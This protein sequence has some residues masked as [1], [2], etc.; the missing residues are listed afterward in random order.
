MTY[1]NGAS[2]HNVE[3]LL[4]SIRTTLAENEH[5]NITGTYRGVSTT[6]AGGAESAQGLV[7]PETSSPLDRPVDPEATAP[8]RTLRN[9]VDDVAEFELPAI[10]KPAPPAAADKPN[11]LLGRLSDALMPAPAG[12]PVPSR[13]VIRFEPA[14]SREAGQPAA[15]RHPVH[16]A[17]AAGRGHAGSD[18][19]PGASLDAPAGADPVTRIAAENEGVKREMPTFFDT[20]MKRLGAPPSPPPEPEPPAVA[21]PVI[22]HGTRPAPQPPALPAA[23]DPAGEA[24]LDDAAAQMLRPLLRQWLSENMPKI[25]EKALR[26]EAGAGQPPVIGG[27][28]RNSEP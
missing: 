27:P 9:A 23:P 12:E 25:V 6:F 10:F 15:E 21:P 11:N 24:T 16:A 14:F 19:G 7:Y 8:A 26:S 22:V 18:Y 5:R 20:R 28:G 2:H 4:Q 3:H 1:T 17:E 13:T